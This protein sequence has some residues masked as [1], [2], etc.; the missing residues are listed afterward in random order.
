MSKFFK[1]QE[2]YAPAIHKAI[3]AD[4]TAGVVFGDKYKKLSEEQIF[5]LFAQK[6]DP[7]FNHKGSNAYKYLDWC[8]QRY[9]ERKEADN[10]IL[11]ED[12]Y[13][14]FDGLREFRTWSARIKKDGQP[15]EIKDIE[16][17]E[18][19]EKVLRPY[20]ARRDQKRADKLKRRLDQEAK[21]Q[22]YSETTILFDGPEGQIVMP[23]TILSSQYW[24]AQTK[25]C[26]SGKEADQAFFT[27]NQK[28]PIIMYL[29]RRSKGF[30]G[31]YTSYK[32]ASVG[33]AVFDE[34]DK[35]GLKSYPKELE[36]LVDAAMNSD[37]MIL[38]DYLKKHGNV[39][40][41]KNPQPEVTKEKI[42]QKLSAEAALIL[43]KIKMFI[44]E[45]S[46]E[47]KRKLLSGISD[48]NVALELV[49][50]YGDYLEHLSPEMQDNEIVVSAALN[51]SDHTYKLKYASAR[52]RDD[53]S[54]IEKHLDKE[55]GFQYLSERLRSNKRIIDMAMAQN[56]SNFEYI[57]PY[58]GFY[59]SKAKKIK[60][61]FNEF[62]AYALRRFKNWKDDREFVESILITNPYA[63]KYI[64]PRLKKDEGLYQLTKGCGYEYAPKSIRQQCKYLIEAQKE[65]YDSFKYAPKSLRS[66]KDVIYECVALHLHILNHV[67]KE[68]LKDRDF[69]LQAVKID[70]EA[71]GYARKSTRLWS[72]EPLF[73]DDKEILEIIYA[74][75]PKLHAQLHAKILEEE[76]SIADWKRH[77]AK[78]GHLLRYAPWKLRDEEDI[79]FSA[80]QANPE[81]LDIN[82]S[83]EMRYRGHQE[84]RWDN[85]TMGKMFRRGAFTFLNDP[86]FMKKKI[87]QDPKAIIKAGARTKSD[88]GCAFAA[89]NGNKELIKHVPNATRCHLSFDWE[90]ILA[91]NCSRIDE[92]PIEHPNYKEIA[93]SFMKQN[94][95]N[96]NRFKS[97]EARCAALSEPVFTLDLLVSSKQSGDNAEQYLRYIPQLRSNLAAMQDVNIAISTLREIVRPS[98]SKNTSLKF[99][100]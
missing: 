92:L 13:K 89:V 78:N 28:Y 53:E 77:V 45:G 25:W 58:A 23:H 91:V 99:A 42:E 96:F 67:P 87:K 32:F 40:Q 44:E 43:E 66:N 47:E 24:G 8:C 98:L 81:I 54:F 100:A 55:G 6:I 18:H 94:T 90:S 16:G 59:P 63:Y 93:I 72:T 12:L 74:R 97:A 21:D 2:Q 71:I 38:Q 84:E 49:G 1:I 39:R 17:F 7:T 50:K 52:L 14:I 29:P 51:S 85:R 65:N 4:E 61:T 37:D 82:F 11:S 64:S 41:I 56:T 75:N 26:I 27:Y 83:V 69:I 88:I 34:Y 5:T 80:V 57:H 9:L 3:L 70:P 46:Y 95:R 68:F 48:V 36:S 33:N 20:Q 79:I 86:K 10:P 76:T 30:G 31:K 15:N 62:S 19:L 73:Q 60:Q 35:A 22:I